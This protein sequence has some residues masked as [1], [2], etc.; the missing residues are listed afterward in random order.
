MKRECL[1]K[2]CYGEH[3]WGMHAGKPNGKGDNWAETWRVTR[4][5]PN[6]KG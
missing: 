6:L 2:P 5:D 3:C 4:N 1:N